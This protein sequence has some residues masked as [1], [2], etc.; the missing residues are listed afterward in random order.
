[1]KCGSENEC[2]C[3]KQPLLLNKN[4]RE[5]FAYRPSLAAEQLLGEIKE[6]KLFGYVQCHIEVPEKL[7]ANFANFPSIFKNTLVNKSD[8][9]DLMKNYAE[10]ER[11]LSQSRKTLISSFTLQN[12]TLITPLLLFYLQLGLFC[13]KTHRFVEY[14]PKKCFNMFVQSVMDARRQ[15]DENPNSSVVAETMK[16]LANSSCGYQIMDR[17]Q[18]SVAKYLTDKKTLAAINSKLF[19]KLDHMNNSLYEVELAEEPIEQKEPI[20]VGFFFLQNAKLRMLELYYNFFTR[21]CDANKFEALEMD[22]DSL[23]LALAE[24]EIED[25][26]RPEIRTE[27]QKLRS[28]DFVDSLTSVAV[29]NFFPRT[30]CVKHKQYDKRELGLFKE[31]FRCTEMLCLCSKTYCCYDVTSNKLKYSS[32]GLNKRVLE[33]SGNG[34]LE[35]YQRVWKEK[36]NNTS[37]KRGFRTNNNSVA[38]Y[39]VQKGLSYFYPK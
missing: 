34:P 1:M 18:R 6:G 36:V 14:T 35:K 24:K 10:E 3:T 16:L 23:Y 12:G 33:Q 19:K 28:N 8:I 15:G 5:H 22:T 29:A 11:L 4:I 25:C 30:C 37:N 39:E 13:T 32:K 20:I 21:F 27:W 7:R 38:T 26:I 2:D 17:S 31:E 9:G